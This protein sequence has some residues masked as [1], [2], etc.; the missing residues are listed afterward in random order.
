MQ[1][2]SR[3]DILEKRLAKT[4]QRRVTRLKNM[5]FD[6]SRGEVPMEPEV[7]EKIKIFQREIHILEV[8]NQ[9]LRRENQRLR[10]KHQ[11]E[12]RRIAEEGDSSHSSSS[13]GSSSCS[14]CTESSTELSDM[15]EEPQPANRADANA[16]E[17]AAQPLESNAV[18]AQDTGYE[19]CNS[20][21]KA[22]HHANS[23]TSAS[24]AVEPKTDTGITSTSGT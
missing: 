20:T 18:N 9:G 4:R 3:I 5:D 11:M 6:I 8:E 21:E 19:S 23:N 12:E 14:T 13:S 17:K 7:A 16:T 15:E 24:N 22:S 10:R 2:E 1:L